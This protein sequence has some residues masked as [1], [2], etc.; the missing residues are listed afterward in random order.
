MKTEI[1]FK[2]GVTEFTIGVFGEDKEMEFSIEN[3][4]DSKYIFLSPNKVNEIVSHLIE[5]LQIIN[6]PVSI[7]N[8][9]ATPKLLKCLE[10]ILDSIPKE[11]ND[12]DWWPDELKASVHEADA[13]INELNKTQEG[14]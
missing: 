12:Q 3:D 4:R 13:L 5:Q 9:S 1:R 7:I 8:T 10:N 11:S 14:K 6:E 2:W